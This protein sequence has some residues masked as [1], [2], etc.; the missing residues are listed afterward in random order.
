[1]KFL[2]LFTIIS[3]IIA[4][5]GSCLMPTGGGTMP[6]N[7]SPEEYR[8]QQHQ[9]A[10]TS[11]GFTIAMIGT[12]LTMIGVLIILIK[13]YRE[14]RAQDAAESKILPFVRQQKIPTRTQVSEGQVSEPLASD[15]QISEP[16]VREPQRPVLQVK[17]EVPIKSILKNSYGKIYYP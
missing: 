1:M 12:S 16:Q 17:R 15:P 6:N 10:I 13:V 9:A 7:M 3:G 11:K 14:N 4:V 2:A 5:I 8:Q